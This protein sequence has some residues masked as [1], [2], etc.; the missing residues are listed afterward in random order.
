MKII[1]Y[2]ALSLILLVMVFPLLWM[3]RVSLMPA[4]SGL[5]FGNFLSSSFTMLIYYDIITS[6]NML[7]YFVNSSIVGAAVTA[8][9][10]LFCFMVGYAL[11]RYRFIGRSFWFYSV[12][13][14]LMI[15][16]HIMIIPLYLLIFRLGLY[17]TYA[18]LIL[19]FLVNPIGIFLVKQYIDTLPS[20]MEEAA[21]ID[22][23]GEFRI[24][25]RVVMPLCKPA[26]A[27]LAIQVFLTNWNS[28]LFPFILTSSES[29]RTLP[30]G[31]ALYQ[32]HQAIDWP[33]LMA[34]SSLAVIPV[35]VIFLLF[36]RH[37]ISGITSGAIKQ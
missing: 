17:D 12:I 10:I 29:V 35:L 36:Q 4:T 33:H 20:S 23:A 25:F 22:G 26:L 18:A 16:V 34:G 30:V 9:N 7:K 5:G 32:G 2:I 8:G 14:V 28:F 21:R 11:S 13:F 19:P 6:G 31:L 1:K 15:P 24:L 3:F 37:I 27:V